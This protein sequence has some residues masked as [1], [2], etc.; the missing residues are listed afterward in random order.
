MDG[1][2]ASFLPPE[3]LGVHRAVTRLLREKLDRDL[4]ERYAV[5]CLSQSLGNSRKRRIFSGQNMTVCTRWLQ[6][7][8]SDPVSYSTIGTRL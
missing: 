6:F 8:R 2:F 5:T 1:R 3:C 7:Y 4:T